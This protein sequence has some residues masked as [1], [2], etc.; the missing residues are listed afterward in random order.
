MNP[1]TLLRKSNI[2]FWGKIEELPFVY[3]FC[4]SCD[5]QL[6]KNSKFHIFTGLSSLRRKYICLSCI[7]MF[8]SREVTKNE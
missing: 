3:P 5:R 7:G 6:D 8:K 4:G 2:W 1:L